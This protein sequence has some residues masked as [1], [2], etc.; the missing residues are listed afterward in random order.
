MLRVILFFCL[1]CVYCQVMECDLSLNYIQN[2]T[3]NLTYQWTI[4]QDTVM[5]N[6]TII[7]FDGCLNV[8]TGVKIDIS[9]YTFT[10]ANN[11][12]CVHLERQ[13]VLMMSEGFAFNCGPNQEAGGV[14]QGFLYGGNNVTILNSVFKH[15]YAT[16]GSV[17]FLHNS[18]LTLLNSDIYGNNSTDVG[19]IN[20][21][22]STATIRSCSIHGNTY[23]TGGTVYLYDSV[24]E[25]S[26]S[27]IKGNTA[28]K[29]EHGIQCVGGPATFGKVII[30]H[31]TY[32]KSDDISLDRCNLT[33]SN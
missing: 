10:G 2:C 14:V 7:C 4:T 23:G 27:V 5:K 21:Y 29:D 30:D 8:D 28:S 24:L 17:I 11:S 26:G 22:H 3:A 13:A 1:H 15:T 32:D 9:N 33:F 16:Y 19:I 6:V 25:I 12:P 20:I 18:T 31:E